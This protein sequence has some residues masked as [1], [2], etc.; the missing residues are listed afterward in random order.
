MPNKIT[1]QDNNKLKKQVQ[2]IMNVK[3]EDYQ[4]WLYNLHQEYLTQ[5]NDIIAKALKFYSQ[6]NTQQENNLNTNHSE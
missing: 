6:K 1:Q 2:Q 3:D 4:E 5:N